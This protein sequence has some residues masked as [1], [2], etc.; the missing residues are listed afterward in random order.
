MKKLALILA[1]AL[2]ASIATAQLY[3]VEGGGTGVKAQFTFTIDDLA[4]TMTVAVNNTI[5]GDGGAFG[6]ITG[7]GFN[8]PFTAAELGVGGANVSFTQSFGTLWNKFVPYGLSPADPFEQDFGVSSGPTEDGGNPPNGVAFGSTATFVF[9]FPDFA[10]DSDFLG[11]NALSVRFQA[12]TDQTGLMGQSDK[13]LGTPPEDDPGDPQFGVP[14]PSTYGL[15]GA[16]LL[17]G[18]AVIRRMR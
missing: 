5:A 15:I 16:M 10:A 14:E 2:F 6:T 3:I 18:L 11:A 8:V 4:N 1:S 9:T 17:M 7:F 12:V 13:V